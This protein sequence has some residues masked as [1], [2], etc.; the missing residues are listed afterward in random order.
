MKVAAIQLN[1]NEDVRNNLL[2]AVNAVVAAAEQGAELVVLPELFNYRGTTKR[3]RSLAQDSN[4]SIVRLFSA[5][6][7][8]LNLNIVLGSIIEKSVGGKKYDTSFF[9]DSTGCLSSSYRKINLFKVKLKDKQID[10]TLYFSKGVSV[11]TYD[12]GGWT[13]A[14]LICFDIRYPEL[15]SRVRGKGVNLFVIPSNFT[16]KTGKAHWESLLRA[17][18]IENQSYIIAANCCGNDPSTKVKSYGNSMIVDPWGEIV[19]FL[20]SEDGV[21]YADIDLEFVNEVRAN[22][23]M[24]CK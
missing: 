18:A 8:S 24:N 13:A 12:V 5:L 2:K 21:A 9:I 15:F 23:P 1:P 19:A 6:A 4:G 22:M 16:N 10:E 11:P 3:Y 14:T 7:K 17:R 20:G